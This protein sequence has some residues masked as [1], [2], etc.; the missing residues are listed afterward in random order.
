MGIVAADETEE[1]KVEYSKFAPAPDSF[2]HSRPFADRYRSFVTHLIPFH[3]NGRFMKLTLR[4]EWRL[5]P[6][7]S[8]LGF[9]DLKTGVTIAVF[10]A[11]LNKVAGVYGLIATLTGA[12]GSAAQITLYIYSAVALLALAWGLTAINAED[13]KRTLYFAHLFFAD[14]VLSTAWTV[15][16]AVHWWVYTPH[17]GRRVS[18]SPAQQALIDGYIGEHQKMSDEQR[19][20]AAELI[21]GQEK[22]LALTIIILGWLSKIYF[23]ALLYSYAHHLRRGTYRSLPLSRSTLQPPKDSA[24]LPS[25][26]DDLDADEAADAFYSPTTALLPLHSPPPASPA[27]Y[28]H[29]GPQ[30]SASSFADFV[31]APPPRRPRRQR[32]SLLSGKPVGRVE[33]ASGS[34]GSTSGGAGGSEAE[35]EEDGSVTSASE[36]AGLSGGEGVG[37][38]TARGGGSG[39]GVSRM[40]GY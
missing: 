12:G 8:F 24:L 27:Q 32:G 7:N 4:Q 35:D 39:N 22:G 40:R 25:A 34:G 11:L 29:R 23:A 1:P 14:H 28:A 21:W 26:E 15:F 37:L 30:N 6:L 2:T 20:A 13:P 5:R 3:L 19:A 16:F 17:D 36:R 18:N 10:F 33:A 31:S 9:L 38:G